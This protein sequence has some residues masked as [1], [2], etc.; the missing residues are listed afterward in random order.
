V[1]PDPGPAIHADR[2]ESV[3]LMVMESTN[4]CWRPFF[5]VLLTSG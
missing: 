5:Y 3:E 2:I 1:R 4:D